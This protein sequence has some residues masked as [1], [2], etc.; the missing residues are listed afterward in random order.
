MTT[1]RPPR[2][3]KRER[4]YSRATPVPGCT[5][6]AH[7]CPNATHTEYHHEAG[8]CVDCACVGRGERERLLAILDGD[9]ATIKAVLAQPPPFGFEDDDDR[10]ANE[11]E[12]QGDSLAA[13][14]ERADQTAITLNP[15]N[16][17]PGEDWETW[18]ARRDILDAAD[19]AANTVTR[20]DDIGP[21]T[22]FDGLMTTTDGTVIRVTQ[23]RGTWEARGDLS[24]TGFRSMH[25]SI[26]SETLPALMRK[27]IEAQR[28][29]F[30]KE[31]ATEARRRRK[32]SEYRSEE[33]PGPVAPLRFDT[34]IK[35]TTGH[36]SQMAPGEI[37]VGDDLIDS[38]PEER[39]GYPLGRH[40]TV[41]RVR[42]AI[43]VRN[44]WCHEWYEVSRAD[45]VGLPPAAPAPAPS[46]PPPT[47]EAPRTETVKRVD[48]FGNVTDTFKTER[49]MSRNYKPRQGVLL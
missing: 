47:T 36:R 37:N 6:H 17:Q 46:A 40:W 19:R 42:P 20:F 11:E 35:S 25:C 4:Q 24:P 32:P 39:Q 26:G 23:W 7:I 41:V 5:C 3:E 13:I 10:D 38:N 33:G 8:G 21:A 29:T 34:A 14:M 31:Q 16:R 2:R 43:T 1:A 48:L 30:L 22:A 9:E 15:A 44:I 18:R 49:E 27:E 28:T 45:I 12:I